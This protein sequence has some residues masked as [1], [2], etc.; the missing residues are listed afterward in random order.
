MSKITRFINCATLSAFNSGLTDGTIKDQNIV[1]IEETSQIWT[2]SKFYS[3]PYTKEEID[4][5]VTKGNI[6]KVLTGNITSHTHN[7]AGSSSAGGAANTAVKLDTPRN[8]SL[9]TGVTSTATEFDGS[10]DITIPVTEVNEQYLK[11]NTTSGKLYTY[12]NDGNVVFP[13]KV[14]ATTFSGSGSE[15]TNITSSSFSDK[16]TITNDLINSLGEGTDTPSD[17]DYYIAQYTG[18][19]TTNTTYYRRHTSALYNYM[20]SK[21]DSSLSS[22]STNY[23]QNKVIN[24]ALTNKVDKENGKQLSTNDYTTDEKNKLASLNKEVAISN[25]EPTGSETIWI[26]TSDETSNF[27]VT[28]APKDGKD[29]VRNNGMW[30][31]SQIGNIN[32]LL[33]NINGEVI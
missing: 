13:N 9:G 6:E 2:H 12:D 21:A 31:E 27:L 33:D 15:L 14:T 19:G 25:T 1:F 11:F 16:K 23:V 22:T 5:L 4:D 24:E 20:K 29:Y 18:G 28:E 17:N 10:S 30:K 7:Y 26:D 3:C 32:A 8:I